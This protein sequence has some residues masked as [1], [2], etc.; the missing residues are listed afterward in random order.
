MKT[1]SFV[2]A[3]LCAFAFVIAGCASPAHND[4]N[5]QTCSQK[6]MCEKCGKPCAECKCA[7][8]KCCKDMKPAET[9]AEQ[10]PAPIP[11]NPNEPTQ[12]QVDNFLKNQNL[13]NIPTLGPVY[14]EWVL[15]MY[16]R[17]YPKAWLLLSTKTQQIMTGFML[18]KM[19][20]DKMNLSNDEKSLQDPNLA[21]DQRKVLQDEVNRLKPY[22]ADREACNG[23][24]EKLYA[25]TTE[26]AC[27]LHNDNPITPILTGTSKWVKEVFKEDIA[28]ALTDDK[29]VMLGINK[30]YFIKENGV[31]KIDMSS[32]LRIADENDP[33]PQQ[34]QVIP[35][36]PA[37]QPAPQGP[38]G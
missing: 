17:D 32:T 31:W 34:Q 28:Y 30:Q 35:M 21:E 29:P 18:Q 33:P 27:K 19:G 22:I 4:K 5:A 15:A 37:P 7:D 8:C 3:I 9:P 2:I 23:D 25:C 20:I 36:Q 16:K 14:K 38:Q 12:E 11:A 24:G 10:K 13:Q 26:T 6:Q 1:S